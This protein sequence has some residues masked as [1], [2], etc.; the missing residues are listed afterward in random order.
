MNDWDFA[1]AKQINIMSYEAV[2]ARDHSF[3]DLQNI[4]K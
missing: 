2:T 1:E 3:C 4:A